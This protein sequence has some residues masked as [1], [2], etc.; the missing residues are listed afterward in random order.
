MTAETANS[1]EAGLGLESYLQGCH[2]FK[3]G[4][5]LVLEYDQKVMQSK[6]FL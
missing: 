4:T 5:V 3:N 1:R 6:Q 2:H